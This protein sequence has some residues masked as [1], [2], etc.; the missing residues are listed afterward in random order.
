MGQE[1]EEIAVVL[2]S[3]RTN[4]LSGRSSVPDSRPCTGQHRPADQ[5]NDYCSTLPHLNTPE[6]GC[7]FARLDGVLALQRSEANP[8]S[9][10]ESK[11]H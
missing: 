7:L 11:L 8:K 4:M 3:V 6:R 5:D 2:K 10:K 9:R 1:C